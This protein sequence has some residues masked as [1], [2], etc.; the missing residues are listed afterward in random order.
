MSETPERI[1][2][3][4]RTWDNVRYYG[5]LGKEGL[6]ERIRSLDEE[7]DAEKSIVVALSGA[8]L[9][10]MV[11]GL[12]GSRF[13][14]VLAWISLPLLFLA[15]QEKWRPSEGILKALGLRSRR[16]IY[17]EKSALKALRGD[18][19]QVDAA[20]GEEGE[21]FARNSARAMDA[22]KA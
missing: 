12:A 1:D 10:G 3:E 18:F 9:F 6:T 17:E 21:A 19:R 20:S 7:W 13:W 5:T 11:M 14:R 22:V 16:E 2:S 4:S 8:G 15:G